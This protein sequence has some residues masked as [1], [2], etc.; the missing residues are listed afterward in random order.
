MLNARSCSVYSVLHNKV[1]QYVTKHDS[2]ITTDLCSVCDGH[3]RN[4]RTQSCVKCGVR[5][6]ASCAGTKLQ[7]TLMFYNFVRFVPVQLLRLVFH[8]FAVHSMHD[9]FAFNTS[10]DYHH[11]RR[12]DLFS[13]TCEHTPP[14]HFSTH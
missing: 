4:E 5:I 6:H 8:P 7:T 11:L 12:R 10:K 9:I 3:K 2:G 14:H 13:I 1:H